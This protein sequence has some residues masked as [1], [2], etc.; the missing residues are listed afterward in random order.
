MESKGKKVTLPLRFGT[1]IKKAI[2]VDIVINQKVKLFSK[3]K[4]K[5]VMSQVIF[6]PFY[7]FSCGEGFK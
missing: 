5:D 4:T 6:I 1:K 3:I 2:G 7:L